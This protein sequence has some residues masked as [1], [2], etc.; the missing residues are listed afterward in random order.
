MPIAEAIAEIIFR[1]ILVFVFYG[2]SYGTGFLL[3][4]AVTFGTIRL[5][6][7]T[8]ITEKNRSKKKWYK[9]D[10]SF[11]LHRPVQG[12]VLKA[13][14]TCLVGMMALVAVGL[15][16]YFATRNNEP[17]ANENPPAKEKSALFA[18]SDSGAER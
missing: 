14:G 13:E 9:I 17:S 15:G 7:L 3:L 10:G 18:P 6:P 5:A 8:S 11:W 16:I 4:K 12:R 1:S 2:L